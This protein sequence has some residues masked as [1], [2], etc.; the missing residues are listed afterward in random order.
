MDYRKIIISG[1]NAELNNI[2]A[3]GII[4]GNG[5][6][7]YNFMP[8]GSITLNSTNYIPSGSETVNNI[9]FQKLSSLPFLSYNNIFQSSVPVQ[10]HIARRKVGHWNPSGNNAT[11][12]GLYGI[13]AHTIIGTSTSRAVAT[14]NL[15]TRSRR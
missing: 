7:L 1:S 3:T 2:T 8:T 15:L 13:P 14:T 6:G 9:Y 10:T 11:V 4:S 12:P 5:S